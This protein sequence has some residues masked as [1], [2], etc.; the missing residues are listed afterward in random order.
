MTINVP[1]TQA[2]RQA[3][4]LA[5]WQ[6]AWQAGDGY[7]IFATAAARATKKQSGGR[8]YNKSNSRACLP[9][10]REDFLPVY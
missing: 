7:V 9:E 4:R 2:G 5:G 10:G 3:G 6:I 8:T 1:R